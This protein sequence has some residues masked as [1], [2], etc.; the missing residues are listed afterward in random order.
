[1]ECFPRP[2]GLVEED[3]A[4]CDSVRW[5]ECPKKRKNESAKYSAKECKIIISALRF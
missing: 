2:A 3:L 5:Q 1:M 4:D